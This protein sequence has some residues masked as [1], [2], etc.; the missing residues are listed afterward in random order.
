L[1]GAIEEFQLFFNN[2]EFDFV[3]LFS[4]GNLRIIVTEHFFFHI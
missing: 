3:K 4:L 1:E 2:F